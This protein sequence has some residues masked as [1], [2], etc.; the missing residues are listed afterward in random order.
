MESWKDL[1]ST[2]VEIPEGE[3]AI[4]VTLAITAKELK[5]VRVKLAAERSKQ[6]R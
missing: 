2:E 1:W 3:E 4:T 6:R 5:E